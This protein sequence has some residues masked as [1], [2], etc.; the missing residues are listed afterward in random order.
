MVEVAGDRTRAYPR[1]RNR[2]RACALRLLLRLRV[3]LCGRLFH[4][5]SQWKPSPRCDPVGPRA[6]Y[7]PRGG[8]VTQR[9]F[10]SWPSLVQFWAVDGTATVLCAK[11]RLAKQIGKTT[12]SDFPQHQCF[13]SSH[14]VA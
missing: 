9:Q 5:A 2:L 8:F 3:L 11:D 4:P 1:T 12:R 7:E 6:R 13:F 14:V 10:A